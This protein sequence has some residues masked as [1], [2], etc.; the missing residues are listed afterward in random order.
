MAI[1]RWHLVA[2][3]IIT[4]TTR[5]MAIDQNK[6]AT[7]VDEILH[8]FKVQTKMP[9]FSMAVSVPPGADPGTYDLTKVSDLGQNVK[10]TILQCGIYA[11]DNVVAATLLRW[12]DVVQRCPRAEVPWQDVLKACRRKS[13]TWHEVAMI[14][15]GAV[16]GNRA[17]HAEYRVL[18]RFD[19]WADDKDKSGLLVLY[20]YTAPCE[21]RCASERNVL[22]I[23]KLLE[24]I[25]DWK[26]YVLVFSKL[27]NVKTLWAGNSMPD[28]RLARALL[29]LGRHL[30]RGGLGKIFRCDQPEDANTNAM[31]CIS[32]STG[33]EVTPQCYKKESHQDPW[34]QSGASAVRGELGNAQ[35]VSTA[36]KRGSASGGAIGRGQGGSENVRKGEGWAPGVGGTE[37]EW[38]TVGQGRQGAVR[39][40]QEGGGAARGWQKGGR[41]GIRRPGGGRRIQGGRSYGGDQQEVGPENGATGQS[42]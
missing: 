24:R 2:L 25:R 27:L 20:V 18:E 1:V 39:M 16:E 19:S 10:N 37:G 36:A 31:E 9:M 13:M 7:L 38:Q 4:T 41:E 26:E 32:C 21:S 34:G 12:P 23:L 40:A 11:G 30:G 14:C 35:G 3:L 28:K 22:S 15:P 29:N 33:G 17:D 6:L 42:E 8:K 5:T